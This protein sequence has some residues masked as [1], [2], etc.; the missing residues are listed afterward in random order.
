LK[1]RYSWKCKE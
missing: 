1:Y